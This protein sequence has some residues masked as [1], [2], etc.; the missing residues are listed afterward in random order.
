MGKKVRH[1]SKFK[2]VTYSILGLIMLL[3]LATTLPPKN[4]VRTTMIINGASPMSVIRCHPKYH[5]KESKFFKMPVYSIPI[6]YA[7]T[8]Q[9][10]GGRVSAFA[11]RSFMGTF[12]VATPLNQFLG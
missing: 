8:D 5:P 12:H 11:I 2:I 4:A 3:F 1:R 6:K 7:Y 9:Q 10:A